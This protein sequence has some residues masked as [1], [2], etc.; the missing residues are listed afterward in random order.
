LRVM[1]HLE[2]KLREKKKREIWGG[3]AP[4]HPGI[5][6]PDLG[7]KKGLQKVKVEGGNPR[8]VA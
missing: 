3:R 4:N 2:K 8:R 5:I 6:G 1:E 7:W